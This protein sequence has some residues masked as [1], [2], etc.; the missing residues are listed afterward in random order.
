MAAIIPNSVFYILSFFIPMILSLVGLP[1]LIRFMHKKGKYGIDIHKKEQPKVAEMGGTIILLSVIITSIILI[2]LVDNPQEKLTLGIFCL[3]LLIA[4]IIGIID[5]L[6]RL[7]GMLKPLLLLIAAIPIIVSGLIVTGIFVPEPL[8]PFVGQTRLTIVYWILLP[9]VITVTSNSVNM[10]DV[11]NGTMATTSMIVLT[12]AFFANLIIFE[13]NFQTLDLTY[14]LILMMIGTL[15]IFWIFNKYPAK[16][17][18]G[19]TGSLTVGAALGIIAILGRLEVVIII[20]MIPFIMN[21]FGIISSVKGLFERGEMARPTKMTDDWKIE[22]TGN[23]KAPITLVGLVIQKGP[24]HEKN[25]A[26]TFNILTLVSGVFALLTAVL[27][28]LTMEGIL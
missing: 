5:D 21:A 13:L 1:L 10:L 7:S 19:D 22:S 27:I 2:F 17:F 28:R 9:F 18:A 15:L 20:A 3:T 6:F 24:L 14:V 11:F 23:P 25:I 8:L 26:K 12:F 16:V 4:G